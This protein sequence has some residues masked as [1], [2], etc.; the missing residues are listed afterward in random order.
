MCY[1]NEIGFLRRTIGSR[2]WLDNLTDDEFKIVNDEIISIFGAVK[3]NR[4]GL[5]IIYTET[6]C[7]SCGYNWVE[8]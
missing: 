6:I 2:M 8:I 7:P 1:L 4:Y 3:R 5:T